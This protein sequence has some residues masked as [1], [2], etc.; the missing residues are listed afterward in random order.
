MLILSLRLNWALPAESCTDAQQ[1]PS[2]TLV[3]RT[4]SPEVPHDGVEMRREQLL[5][6]EG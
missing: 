2:W 1:W 5:A 6:Y 3:I 4:F